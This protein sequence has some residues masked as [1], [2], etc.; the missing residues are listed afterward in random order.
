MNV[1]RRGLL[2]IGAVLVL[3]ATVQAALV[4]PAFAT[5][6]PKRPHP[7]RKPWP[8]TLTVQTVPTL[9]GV[10]VRFDDQE[11]LTDAHG[12]ATFT[13]EHNFAPHTLRLLDT[14]VKLPDRRYRFV[15]WAGQRDPDQAYESTVTGLPMR[16]N[17]TVTAGFAAST[18]VSIGLVDPAGDLVNPARLTSVALRSG[19]QGLIRVPPSGRLWLD[20]LI[21]VYRNSSIGLEHET[22]SLVSVMVDGTNTVDAGKQSFAPST[23]RSPVF[24]TKFFA[25]TVTGHDLFFH[26]GS[27]TSAQV[28]YPD[29]RRRTFDFGPDGTAVV[30]GLA[31]GTYRVT[32]QGG[33]TPLASDIVLSRDTT[34]DTPIATSLDLATAG[35]VLLSVMVGLLVI[36]RGRRRLLR[37]ARRLSLRRSKQPPRPSAGQPAPPDQRAQDEP[38]YESI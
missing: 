19:R 29:G 6:P 18:P 17:A 23:D 30:P 1:V 7:H 38:E 36:G 20:S 22:Y 21:P 9:K 2:R 33:G 13:Q 34:V 4:V 12:R 25:L 14:S 11:R 28:T 32:V 16:M 26:G 27:G 10:Q 15:R 3:V 37:L 8:I 24:G 35:L 5:P 31:R